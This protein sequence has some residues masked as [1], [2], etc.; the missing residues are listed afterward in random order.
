MSARRFVIEC[1]RR[2]VRLGGCR[3]PWMVC[4]GRVGGREGQAPFDYYRRTLEEL[5]KQP[6]TLARI[7]RNAE[8]VLRPLSTLV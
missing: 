8:N 4:R 5:V 6:G 3:A 2:P 1:A 7:F